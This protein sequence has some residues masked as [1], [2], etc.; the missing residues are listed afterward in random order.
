MLQSTTPRSSDKTASARCSPGALDRG[1]GRAPPP[2]ERLSTREYFLRNNKTLCV[3][4]ISSNSYNTSYAPCDNVSEVSGL[5]RDLFKDH[6][7][8]A[9]GAAVRRGR[10][11][12][13]SFAARKK[14][15]ACAQ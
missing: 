13:V 3:I 7:E 9:A 8:P 15:A 10:D 5:D 1:R 14:C 12:S 4:Q 11:V 2:P 6:L